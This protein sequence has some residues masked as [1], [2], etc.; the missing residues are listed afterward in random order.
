MATY[1]NAAHAKELIYTVAMLNNNILEQ[2][3]RLMGI[4]SRLGALTA[5]QRDVVRQAVRDMG[6]DDAEIEQMLTRWAAV[7]ATRNAQ[8]LA[9]VEAP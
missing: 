3:A 9:L 7:D 6:F 5:G 2:L 1:A 4:R 8:G